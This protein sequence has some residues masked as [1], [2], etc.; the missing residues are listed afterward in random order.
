VAPEERDPYLNEWN[1]LVDAIRADKPYNEVERGVQA[2]LATSMGRMAAHTGQEISFEQLLNSDHEYAP[3][4]DQPTM[5]SPPPL[6]SGPDG[7]YPI[8]MPGIK[9][10]REY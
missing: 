8:P 1:D 5:D 9:K 10:D 2:S 4:V 7:K 3:G 6:R